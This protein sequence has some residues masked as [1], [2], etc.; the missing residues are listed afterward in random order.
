METAEDAQARQDLEYYDEDGWCGFIDDVICP[1]GGWIMRAVTPLERVVGL[2]AEAGMARALLEL[3]VPVEPQPWHDN[4][5]PLATRRP[6][7]PLGA[8]LDAH[9]LE[10][11]APLVVREKCKAMR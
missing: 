6:M 1:R 7:Q 9:A 8:W 11:G 5:F 2:M 4:D 10:F 3:P